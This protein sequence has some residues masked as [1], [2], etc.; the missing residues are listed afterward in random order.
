VGATAGS[1]LVGLNNNFNSPQRAWIT[2]M[3][4]HSVLGNILT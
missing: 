1:R 3:W 2:I 4:K